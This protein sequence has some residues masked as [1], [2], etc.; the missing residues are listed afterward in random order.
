MKTQLFTFGK[1]SRV[2]YM[3]SNDETDNRQPRLRL[4]HF[5][6]SSFGFNGKP[7]SRNIKNTQG[8]PISVQ[9]IRKVLPGKPKHVAIK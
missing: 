4:H 5:T 9:P 1:F 6:A 3:N 8:K 7:S 2:C